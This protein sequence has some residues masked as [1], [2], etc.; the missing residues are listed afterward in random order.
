MDEGSGLGACMATGP[1]DG[2]LAART[3]SESGRRQTRDGT[4]PKF[5]DETAIHDHLFARLRV[6][7]MD[8]GCSPRQ[9]GDWIAEGE[10]RLDA[11]MRFADHS[12]HHEEF[13]VAFIECQDAAGRQLG[14]VF[15]VRDGGPP[16]RG[17][18]VIKCQ[19]RADIR[20]GQDPHARR[21]T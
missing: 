9:R 11:E 21:F 2:K 14:A 1:D 13:A 8:D 12:R 17:E 7:E 19:D 3:R 5:R 10:P 4:G 16:G 18:D 6:N 20:C 15:D